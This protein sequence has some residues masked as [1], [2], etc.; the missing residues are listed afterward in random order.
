M[1]LYQKFSAAV[2]PETAVGFGGVYGMAAESRFQSV[3]DAVARLLAFIAENLK[4]LVDESGGIE[5][6]VQEVET[7]YRGYIAP[8]DIPGVPNILEP[9]VDTALLRIITATVRRLYDAV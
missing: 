7:F 5:K 6:L 3:I 4:S 9:A 2:E 8:L 1:S